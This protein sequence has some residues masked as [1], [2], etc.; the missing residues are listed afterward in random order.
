MPSTLTVDSGIILKL[1]LQ[2]QNEYVDCI[3][4]AQDKK[5]NIP[6]AYAPH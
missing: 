6:Y 1:Q 5:N 3:Y 4:F 2:K